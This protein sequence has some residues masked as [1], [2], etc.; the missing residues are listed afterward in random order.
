MIRIDRSFVET[1]NLNKEV[2]VIANRE[3]PENKRS[4]TPQAEKKRD[5]AAEEKEILQKAAAEADRI[6]ADARLQSDDIK[7]NAWKAGYS[8]GKARAQ[9]EME[10][11]IHEQQED[12]KR[13]F[14]KLEA[15]KQDLYLDLLDNVLELSFDIA[16]KIIHFNLQRDDDIY[17][18]IARK[19][20][21]ALNPSS[22]LVLRVS[23][24]EYDRFFSEDGQWLREDIGSLP[25]EVVCDP[26]MSQ[27]GF[28]AESDEGVVNAGVGE[29]LDKLKRTLNG[30]VQ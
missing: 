8:D 24:P 15:Y 28:I 30:R 21:Q 5:V 10:A 14:K 7:K 22:K 19:A 12:A 6:V 13:V 3:V 26:G 2:V 27:G 29:Q 11:A 20:I 4:E 16:E 23:R 25:F 18:G 1:M 9:R 17:K